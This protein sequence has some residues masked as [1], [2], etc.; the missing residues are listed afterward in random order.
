MIR[1][2][3][4]V[5]SSCPRCV[6]QSDCRRCFVHEWS[7]LI[8]LFIAANLWSTN[9]VRISSF[10]VACIF[11]GCKIVNCKHPK[12]NCSWSNFKFFFVSLKP[13]K[14][15][16]EFVFCYF[17]SDECKISNFI[18]DLNFAG[19]MQWIRKSVNDNN[20]DLSDFNM[21]FSQFNEIK[22]RSR[23]TQSIEVSRTLNTFDS[24]VE[25]FVD[26]WVATS[27]HWNLRK[28]SHFRS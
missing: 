17:K 18:G 25:C 7:V 2:D 9:H 15:R 28:L 11:R 8:V 26:R 3:P 1:F 16:I 21:Q 12:S 20:I 4:L 27:K 24:N 13:P 14:I 22:I 6:V 19:S 10:H 23:E 5:S